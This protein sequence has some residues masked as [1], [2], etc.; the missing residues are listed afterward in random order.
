MKACK[1]FLSPSVSSF[2]SVS[3]ISENGEEGLGT[4]L[5]NTSCND[6]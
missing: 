2:F 1:G 6:T 5:Q 3:H 4:R